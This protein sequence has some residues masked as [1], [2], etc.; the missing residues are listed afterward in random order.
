MS[1]VEKHSQKVF[2]RMFRQWYPISWIPHMTGGTVSRGRATLRELSMTEHCPTHE[3]SVL[4][5]AGTLLY[6]VSHPIIHRDF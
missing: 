1:L 2:C 6:R 3:D 5:E 4:E